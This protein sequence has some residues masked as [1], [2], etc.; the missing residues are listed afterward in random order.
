MHDMVL[1]AQS[2]PVKDP[3]AEVE[4]AALKAIGDHSRG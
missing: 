2:T 3:G 1:N 4:V